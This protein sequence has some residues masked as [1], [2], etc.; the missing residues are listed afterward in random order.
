M[1][2]LVVIALGYFILER[3]GIFSFHDLLYKMEDLPFAD[4][5]R[6]VSGILN[7]IF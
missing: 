7:S 2:L 4:H 3:F 5:I 1:I 6:S